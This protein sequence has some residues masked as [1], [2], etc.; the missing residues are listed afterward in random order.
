METKFRR[1]SEKKSQTHFFKNIQKEK[2]RERRYLV[3][4]YSKKIELSPESKIY[5]KVTGTYQKWELVSS[6]IGRRSFATNFYGE[7]PT[8][9]LMSAT[10]HTTEAM[11]L[12]YIGKTQTQQAKE[13][14]KYW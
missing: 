12:E 8:V 2:S 5:R 4:I 1:H 3:R 11:F 14:A 6:H 10:G 9:L 13:L 7:I